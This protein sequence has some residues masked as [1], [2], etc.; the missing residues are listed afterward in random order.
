MLDPSN[1]LAVTFGFT[2]TEYASNEE[3]LRIPVSVLKTQPI[4]HPVTLRIQ[5]MTIA[6]ALTRGLSIPLVGGVD[7]SVSDT[8]ERRRVPVRAT[9]K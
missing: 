7:I 5:P 6:E 4:A 1:S 9:G 2:A 3:Q 8:D